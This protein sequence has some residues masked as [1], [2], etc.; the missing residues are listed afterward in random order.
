MQL[1]ELF[2]SHKQVDP[3]SFNYQEPNLPEP[4]YL[5]KERAKEVV[6]SK[7]IAEDFES[8]NWSVPKPESVKWK[9]PYKN[10]NAG[11]INDM[12]TAYKKA[13]LS[14]NAIKNLIAKNALES[15]WGNSVQGDFN[16]GNITT[17][18]SWKGRFVQGNDKDG[19]GKKISQ[20]FRA[21]NSIDDYVKDEIQLLTDSYDFNQDDDFTT[22]TNK[23]TGQNSKKK[24][25][26]ED[27][28]YATKLMGVYN[29]G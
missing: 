24:R 10:N 7:E 29:R 23:L 2:V 25:Y 3:I 22:F 15:G 16:F 8:T 14:D 17:G 13:G 27:K 19:N 4:I 12:T 5:N 18:S 6:S 1:S 20:K 9:N 28:D 11:W 21:Y 26:A